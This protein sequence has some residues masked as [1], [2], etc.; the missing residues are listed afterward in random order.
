MNLI[1]QPAESSAFLMLTIIMPVSGQT[2]K[3]GNVTVHERAK[4]KWLEN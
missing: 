2:E 1:M 4:Q 3:N